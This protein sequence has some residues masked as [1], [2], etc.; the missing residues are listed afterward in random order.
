MTKL[1]EI[2]ATVLYTILAR[3]IYWL[4]EWLAKKNFHD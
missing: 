1:R 2:F 4:A 3:P